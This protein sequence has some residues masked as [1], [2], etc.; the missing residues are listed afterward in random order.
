MELCLNLHSA[1]LP[2]KAVLNR[3]SAVLTFGTDITIHFI[4]FIFWFD[5]KASNLW[6][7]IYLLKIPLG[8]QKFSP[9]IKLTWADFHPLRG[10]YFPNLEAISHGFLFSLFYLPFMSLNN[11]VLLWKY[12]I[13]CV[14]V[15]GVCVCMLCESRLSLESE[16]L[17]R[18]KCVCHWYQACV[19]CAPVQ[20]KWR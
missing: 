16:Q 12:N 19:W 5:V 4:R 11:I 6:D 20:C 7:W 9:I 14:R 13:F 2:N 3:S 8:H 18:A 15:D 17:A 10:K 1:V